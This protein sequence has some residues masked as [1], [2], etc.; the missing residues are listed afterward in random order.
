MS[1]LD[2]V[3]LAHLRL[4]LFAFIFPHPSRVAE[5][6]DPGLHPAE[7]QEQ[8]N[9]MGNHLKDTAVKQGFL[10]KSGNHKKTWHRRWFIL[11]DSGCGYFESEGDTAPLGV[12]VA[13]EVMDVV[14]SVDGETGL[15]FSFRVVA[16]HR[17]YDMQASNPRDLA[18]WVSAFVA[19]KA[20]GQSIAC[21]TT[22][23]TTNDASGAATPVGRLHS[24]DTSVLSGGGDT[25]QPFPDS[26][27]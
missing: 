25:P 10:M 24:L 2:R 11:S 7:E 4:A 1:H 6:C 21:A 26:P 14:A 23:I 5:C 8:L 3:T 13:N 20:R 9:A 22:V 19:L 17:H 27:G 18:R 15:P 16:P 12:F